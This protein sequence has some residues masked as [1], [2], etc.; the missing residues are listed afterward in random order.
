[1]QAI[2]PTLKLY[3]LNSAPTS[4]SSLQDA[5]SALKLDSMNPAPVGPLTLEQKE[6][7]LKG[8]V[9]EFASLLYAQ[10]I[11][12]MRKAGGDDEDGDGEGAFGG[13]DTANFMDMFDRQVGMNFVHQGGSGLKDALYHQLITNLESQAQAEGGSQ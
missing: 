12:E 4:P 9:D 6:A 3:P 13:G 1:M 10:M 2:N 8:Q 11:A 5:D 7:K